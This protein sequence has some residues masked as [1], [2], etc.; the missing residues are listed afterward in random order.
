MLLSSNLAHGSRG[1][2]RL[3][4]KLA[5]CK[6]TL[7]GNAIQQARP[8]INTAQSVCPAEAT[9]LPTSRIDVLRARDTSTTAALEAKGAALVPP[10]AGDMHMS[11]QSQYALW[12]AC[13]V[14]ARSAKRLFGELQSTA[15]LLLLAGSTAL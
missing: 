3:A 10:Y 8:R 9:T 12:T 4:P 14:L 2:Q 13:L 11:F 5:H 6:Y 15:E 7:I 1:I